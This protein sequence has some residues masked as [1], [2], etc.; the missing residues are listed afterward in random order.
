MIGQL[1][2]TSSVQV[3]G[4]GIAGLSAAFYLKKLG[5]QFRLWESHK[6]G[7]K[8]FPAHCSYGPCEF[9]A[10]SFYLSAQSQI[11]LQDLGLESVPATK[12]LKKLIF[13]SHAC[14]W[15]APSRIILKKMPK[16]I[17]RTFFQSVESKGSPTLEQMFYPLLG[18]ELTQ[19][20]VSAVTQGIY[21]VGASQL[22]P[23]LMFSPETL[24]SKGYLT[25]LARLRAEVKALRGGGD[26]RYGAANFPGG[27]G[28]LIERLREELHD[29]LCD[30]VG[31]YNPQLCNVIATDAHQ[32]AGILQKSHP[33]VSYQLRS[34]EYLPMTSYVLYLSRPLTELQGAF[35][36]LIPLVD[37]Q[38]LQGKI[39]GVINQ[40]Q[41]FPRHS[42][43]SCYLFRCCGNYQSNEDFF[44]EL[45][46]LCP[47]FVHFAE[48][49]ILFCQSYSWN[50]ALPIYNARLYEAQQRIRELLSNQDQVILMGNYTAGISLRS[51]IA[52]SQEL[53]CQGQ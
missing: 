18:D 39:M 21:G 41:V 23:R 17:L 16:L 38:H 53:L 46:K 1:S 7:G 36:G 45:K 2:R 48:N 12:K 15:E 24:Q 10:S 6:L 14:K 42:R 26:D 51:I 49:E 13:N 37:R 28:T 52:Q 50:K 25:L 8:I 20:L 30:G 43:F 47:S 22:D 5:K 44:Q 27:M 35:G 19:R 33:Q 34:I 29:H 9:A 40:S 11:F 32:A 3:I 31:V 4:G